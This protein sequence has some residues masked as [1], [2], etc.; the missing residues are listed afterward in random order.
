[1][2]ILSLFEKIKAFA[3]DLDGVLTD[4]FLHV[5][6]SGEMLRRMSIKDGYAL[7][8]AAKKG[9]KIWIISGGHS[10]ACMK[11]LQNLGIQDIFIGVEDKLEKLQ[12]LINASALNQEQVLYM[13][14][15][16]PDIACMHHS[17]LATCPND[18][19]VEVCNAATYISPIKGGMGCVRD[20]IEKVLKINNDWE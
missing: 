8:L 9:Y 5:Q 4:G 19:A 18:A 20:V 3:F 17:G 10:E 14:D 13:G 7:K 6:E 11:R 15:D 2:N 12:E 16:M 1:M